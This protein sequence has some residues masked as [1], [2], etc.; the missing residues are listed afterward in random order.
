MAFA[1]GSHA[2]RSYTKCNCSWSPLQ[3]EREGFHSVEA[4]QITEDSSCILFKVCHLDKHL[5]NFWQVHPWLLS[6]WT[7]ESL[8]SLCGVISAGLGKGRGRQY[9][10]GWYFLSILF[11]LLILS[12]GCGLLHSWELTWARVSKGRILQIQFTPFHNENPFSPEPETNVF[13]ETMNYWAIFGE[14]FGEKSCLN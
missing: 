2:G 10:G 8:W 14:M 12:A 4:V 13:S 11:P 1:A 5:S 3:L 9:C 7:F 6:Q